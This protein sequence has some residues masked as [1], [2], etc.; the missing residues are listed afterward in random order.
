MLLLRIIRTHGKI[1]LDTI[2]QKLCALEQKLET[3]KSS[4]PAVTPPPQKIVMQ[5][6]AVQPT[7]PSERVQQ[8]SKTDNLMQFA[9][10]ELGG[11]IQH[12]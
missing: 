6:A 9:A 7:K 10:K 12:G 3:G 1:Q 11:S 2:V 5:E 4:Q 8:K